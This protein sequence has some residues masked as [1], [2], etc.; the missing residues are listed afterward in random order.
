MD[1]DA[2][3]LL[4][5]STPEPAS[6]PAAVGSTPGGSTAGVPALKRRIGLK[7]SRLG[8]LQ[9]RQRRKK[10]QLQM[11]SCASCLQRNWACTYPSTSGGSTPMAA[12]AESVEPPAAVES[13]ALAPPA[14]VRRVHELSPFAIEASKKALLYHFTAT[15]SDLISFPARQGARCDSPFL[16]YVMPLALTSPGAQ[17]DAQPGE[18]KHV[19]DLLMLSL[20]AFAAAHQVG[21]G[22]GNPAAIEDASQAQLRYH[23]DAVKTLLSALNENPDAVAL[24][25]RDTGTEE[26][27]TVVLASILV[28]VYYEIATG[29]DL[30]SIGVHLSGA[31]NII[32]SFLDSF[33]ARMHSP[34]APYMLSKK[35][36]FLFKLFQYFD[37]ISSLS[38]R[39][40]LIDHSMRLSN[41][42]STYSKLFEQAG[43][44][45]APRRPGD[46]VID[47]VIGLAKDI[48]PL[49][50]R[51]C[52]ICNKT[53]FGQ[54]ISQEASM[55][56]DLLELELREWTLA[57]PDSDVE[58]IS[59]HW[60][61][62]VYQAAALIY[63]IRTFSS[64]HAARSTNPPN[65]DED[66]R[67]F[68]QIGLDG[69]S[70]V[71]TL[72]GNMAAL[73]WPVLIIAQECKT[74]MDRAL[75]RVIMDKLRRRQG[76]AN[77]SK[78]LELVEHTWRGL[79][80]QFVMFG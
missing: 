61:A 1:R 53:Y 31:Y 66:I 49:V 24:Q 75:V 18:R 50:L 25:P 68:I 27:Q 64:R 54:V 33:F 35:T 73:L 67:V 60:A 11:P 10:C 34:A 4:Q 13:R 46:V 51:L 57:E 19:S 76:M 47:P 9:C 14:D 45:P 17:A 20:C 65:P 28:L 7:R 56:I 63:L 22:S 29:G 59:L 72:D 71:C 77:V 79:P 6:T 39:A 38:Q 78:G 16:E 58:V 48:W 80:G 44:T 69:L 30:V 8:C 2:Q 74:V 70:R 21:A 40:A 37:V 3:F 5:R 41:F 42:L 52:V 36:V 26:G 43:V 23:T 15:I 55:E 32:N 12:R 62:K